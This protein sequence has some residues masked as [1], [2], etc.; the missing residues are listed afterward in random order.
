MPRLVVPAC[1]SRRRRRMSHGM[2]TEHSRSS[3][4]TASGV[5]Q[6]R[7]RSPQPHAS[8]ISLKMRKSLRAC[9]GALATCLMTAE[10]ALGVDEHPFLFSPAGGRQHEVGEGGGLGRV[11]YM[12]CTTRKSSRS[13]ISCASAWLI[14][15]CAVLVAMTHRPRIRPFRMPFHDLVVGPTRLAGNAR[16]VDAQ[17][18]GHL[19]A[20]LRVGEIVAA[21]QVGGVAEQ[22]RAHGV[23]LAGDGVGAG[24]RP[25]D[26][27]RHQGQVDD[28]LRRAHALVPLV[29]AH[30][31][32]ERHPPGRR[33]MVR[34]QGVRCRRRSRPQR[35]ATASGGN[36]SRCSLNASK[37]RWCGRR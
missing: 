4:K 35:S 23:A 26:V 27:A 7:N 33:R 9:P 10:A 6:R 32:P 14:H 1:G 17:D 2:P 25:A 20:V 19:G 30:R 5:S 18:A 22:P 3:R 34:R 8:A 24:A 28:R 15:E 36:P 13:R 31:P 12:S 16:R 29:H 11:A 21:E 37:S